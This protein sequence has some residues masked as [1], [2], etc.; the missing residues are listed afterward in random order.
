[1]IFTGCKLRCSL[2]VLF[3]AISSIHSFAGICVK[4]N[5]IF[6]LNNRIVEPNHQHQ[7]SLSSKTTATSLSMGYGRERTRGKT[8]ERSKRQ[9]RVG[10][11]IQ[12]EVAKIIH[13]GYTIKSEEIIEEGLR[14][15]ISVVNVNMSPDLRQARI[16]ISVI[17]K[18]IIEK[19]RAYSWLVRSSKQI[20]HS[21][22]Q[23]MKHMKF[24]PNLTFVH[25]DV[26]S[27]VDVMDLIDKISTKGYKRESLDLVFEDDDDDWIDDD[28]DDVGFDDDD[29]DME[30]ISDL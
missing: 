8:Q 28:D 4:N 14:Q 17:G 9:E 3:C 24:C 27:A 10:Q 15:K 25:A 1:M 16:T 12:T 2:L 29:I 5:N 6:H 20:K 23:R 18:E 22:A 21:L 11:L 26:G 7:Q 13:Q 30:S 19:R